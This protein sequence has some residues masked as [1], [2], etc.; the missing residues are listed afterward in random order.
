M[1]GTT[2]SGVCKGTTKK[3]TPC[4]RKVVFANGLCRQHGGDSSEYDRR[5]FEYL[6]EKAIRRSTKVSKRLRRLVEKFRVTGK[7]P[8]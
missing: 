4:Q 7:A 2:F 3:G 1:A 6:K 8:R 5:H